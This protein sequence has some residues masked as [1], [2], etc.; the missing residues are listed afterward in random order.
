MICLHGTSGW[1]SLNSTDKRLIASPITVRWC[2]TA[3]GKTSSLRNESSEVASTMASILLQAERMSFRNDGSCR[4]DDPGISENLGAY[5][6]FQSAP[7]NQV[8]SARNER[9]QRLDERLELNQT[10]AN[11]GLELHHDVDVALGTH[12]ATG[13]RAKHGKLFDTVVPAQFRERLAVDL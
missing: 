12:L 4:I 1:R 7:G 5:P 9:L 2:S 3:A 11:P 13:S 10:N 6:W 8:D